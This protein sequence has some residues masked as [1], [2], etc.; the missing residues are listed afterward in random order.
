MPFTNGYDFFRQLRMHPVYR[1]I[2]FL[3]TT[4]Q[5]A[6]AA[7]TAEARDM[8]R[9]TAVKP[10]GAETLLRKIEQVI[11]PTSAPAVDSSRWDPRAAGMRRAI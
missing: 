8:L 10:F 3:L 6:E 5:E 4:T 9:A 2:P 1:H 7:L 11:D